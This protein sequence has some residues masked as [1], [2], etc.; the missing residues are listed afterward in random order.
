MSSLSR[1]SHCSR[2]HRLRHGIRSRVKS[3]VDDVPPRALRAPRLA[4]AGNG[5]LHRFPVNGDKANLPAAPETRARPTSP[6]ICRSQQVCDH[7]PVI[8]SWGHRSPAPHSTPSQSRTHAVTRSSSAT[9][10]SSD[11][12]RFCTMGDPSHNSPHLTVSLAS[13][14]V[15]Q[16]V[17]P[18]RRTTRRGTHPWEAVGGRGGVLCVAVSLP[19]LSRT[20]GTERGSGERAGVRG[21]AAGGRRR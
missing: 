19:P 4:A 6:T 21:H 12:A 16:S 17:C 20:S 3:G 15:R 13:L 2:R 1:P 5:A 18:T 8:P 14:T 11:P 10:H 7:H 9:P